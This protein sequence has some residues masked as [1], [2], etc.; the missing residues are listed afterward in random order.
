[1]PQRRPASRARAA[2][3]KIGLIHRRVLHERSSGSHRR[4]A[5]RRA[6]ARRRQ[7]RVQILLAGS[8]LLA[9]FALVE[10]WLY[11]RVALDLSSARSTLQRVTEDPRS[12]IDAPGRARAVAQIDA[13]VIKLESAQRRADRLSTLSLARLV[14]A[15][16]AQRAGFL[17][18]LDDTQAA[19]ATGRTLLQEIGSLHDRL[20][21]R[22][23]Q[24]P[25]QGLQLL[26]ASVREAG[27]DLGALARPSQGAWWP[28][29]EARDAL[30]EKARSSS[31][32][33]AEA[34]DA[35]DASRSFLGGE[36][37]RR[38][39]VALQNNAEMRDQGMVLSYATAQLTGGRFEFVRNGSTHGDL[40]LD[41]PAPIPV[42]PGTE[43]VFG[44]IR[45]SQEWRSVNATADFAWSA[46]AMA[47]MYWQAT[48]EPID[49]VMAIDVPGV[50]ALLRVV[51]QV[52]VAGIG[53]LTADN[54]ARTLL[55][56]LYEGLLPN[57][58]ALA[59]RERLG[60]VTRAVVDR[61]TRG[62]V[63]V[64]S[65]VGELGK[66]V[67]G[68]HLR[69]WSATGAEE[70]VFER[71][72]IGG[73]PA[74]TDAD[75]TFHLAV[76]N[77]T[78]TKLDYFVQPSVRHEVRL[79][80]NG[81]AVVRTTVVVENRAPVGASPSLQ[82]GPDQ[83]TRQAG[84]YIGWVLLWGPNGSTQQGG[85]PESGL[86]LSES[87]VVV[88]AG[89][90]REVTFQTTIPDA[91]RDGRVSLRLVPQPRLNAV[92]LDVRLKAPGW[93]VEGPAAW[94]GPWDQVR[95]LTWNV[96]R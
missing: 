39:F 96:R 91:V 61:L 31:R 22:D 89:E 79:G 94:S 73:G 12:F 68:G 76:Q 30:N 88:G 63:D 27:Q 44:P 84:D 33:L 10:G 21:L 80:E 15:L 25:L 11:L 81:D 35:L 64:V 92:H 87:V 13:A 72:G 23:G 95:T 6:V 48:G 40:R 38:V 90:R 70:D 85:T 3:P 60:D 50:A 2:R 55:S 77:R 51:G 5:S 46:R 49:G 41:R 4:T 69:L 67:D 16:R 53:T 29:S 19:A 82:L 71:A 8:A 28:L 56:D 42:P 18:L 52:D 9:A 34:S 24:L 78:A 1:M 45:P 86:V 54:A 26:S 66:M 36:G 47:A 17:S 74:A 62:E 57:D 43:K 83:V 20:R 65:L 14:P 59:R 7:R 58:D 75:R 32:R 93:G 37:N